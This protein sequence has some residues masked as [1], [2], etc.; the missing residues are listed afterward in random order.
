MGHLSFH[1]AG[2]SHGPALSLQIQGLPKGLTFPVERINHWLSLRKNLA[3]RGLRAPNEGDRWRVE[4]GVTDGLTNGGILAITIAN[5]DRS[6]Q[7][8]DRSGNRAGLEFPRPGHADLAG[9]LKWGLNDAS[10]VAELASARLTATY[11]VVGAI[12]QEILAG[13]GLVSVAH[14][15]RIGGVVDRRR[16]WKK[17]VRLAPVLAALENSPLLFLD[18][19]KE[20]TALSALDAARAAGDTLGG[21]FEVV[22]APVRPGLGAP[23][24]LYGRLDSRI[25]A[26][27][28]GIPGVVAV[29]IGD[30]MDAGRQSGSAFHSPLLYTDR[31][32]YHYKHNRAGGIEGGMTNGH[33]VVVRAMVKPLASLGTPMESV[34]LRDQRPGKAPAVRSDICAVAPAAVVARALVAFVLADAWLDAEE[35]SAP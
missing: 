4:S 22:M 24:P 29:S 6:G 34:S 20:Q 27:V 15:T 10:P 31:N 25:A 7:S 19:R 28:M 14:A 35:D 3:G 5:Q 30:G 12:C 18:P 32:G 8:V 16:D 21:A 9:A 26:A 11:T 13:R 17:G 33:P 1:V 2:E 23:Q